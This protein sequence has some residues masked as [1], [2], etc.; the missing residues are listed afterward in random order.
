MFYQYGTTT[1]WEF[2]KIDDA[3]PDPFDTDRT[4]VLGQNHVPIT[5]VFNR[6][7][8]IR[9]AYHRAR[10]KTCIAKIK[11]AVIIPVTKIILLLIAAYVLKPAASNATLKVTTVIS[12]WSMAD[13]FVVAI[14]VAFLASNAKN[15]LED[16]VILKA[17]LHS[18]FYFFL[19]YCLFSIASS[20]LL[21]P[22]QK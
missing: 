3:R 17:T 7:F 21:K 1:V 5:Q 12:K 18:G 9:R 6:H 13:V 19:A 20:Y 15:D 14:L 11:L 8:A 10:G 22:T 16:L 2:H 4:V